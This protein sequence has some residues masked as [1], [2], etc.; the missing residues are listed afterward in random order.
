MNIMKVSLWNEATSFFV[1][2][3]IHATPK[4]I[5]ALGSSKTFKS[6]NVSGEA[7]RPYKRTPKETNPKYPSLILKLRIILLV[8]INM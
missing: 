5:N 6:Y 3:S 1:I 8:L 4:D 7:E 2:L